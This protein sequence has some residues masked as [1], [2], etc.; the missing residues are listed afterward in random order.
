MDNH[1]EQLINTA[2]FARMQ[3]SEAAA[4]AADTRRRT[5][6]MRR[7]LSASRQEALFD[8][9]DGTTTRGET[10]AVGTAGGT[11]PL[12]NMSDVVA[13]LRRESARR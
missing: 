10:A 7:H 13:Q 12:R 11:R 3:A 4:T 2:Q 6:A 9:A 5:S 8:A 1:T